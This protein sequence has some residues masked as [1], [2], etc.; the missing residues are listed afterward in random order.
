MINEKK[1]FLSYT[2]CNNKMK[3]ENSIVKLLLFKD[4]NFYIN[5]FYL[6]YAILN[7]FF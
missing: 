4:V 3:K 5:K 7:C 1:G 6:T 2:I